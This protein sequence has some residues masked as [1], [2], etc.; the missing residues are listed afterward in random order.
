MHTL[1]P[2]F[3]ASL[4]LLGLSVVSLPVMAVTRTWPGAAPCNTTL[5]ACIAGTL[6]GDRIEIATDTPINESPNLFERDIELVAANG[7][8]PQLS[9]GRNLFI[10]SSQFKGNQTVLV[11]GIHLR[12]GY[13]SANYLGYATANYTIQ[14]MTLEA[15]PGNLGGRISSSIIR[16][17]T[18]ARTTLNLTLYNND[19][20]CGAAIAESSVVSMTSAASTTL[21]AN[22]YNNKVTCSTQDGVVNY[23]IL[24]SIGSNAAGVADATLK[25]HGNEIRAERYTGSGTMISSMSGIGIREDSDAL[26]ASTISARLYNN[27]VIG[28]GLNSSSNGIFTIVDRGDMNLQTV[29]NTI[30]GW[31]SSLYAGSYNSPGTGSQTIHGLILNNV[32]V[33]R[34]PAFYLQGTTTASLSNTYN[35]V[36]APST[37]TPLGG[38]SI[39]SPAKLVSEST[40]RLRSDSPAIGAADTATLAFG[41]ALGGLPG[42]D[43]DGLRRVKGADGLADIGAYEF[44]DVS[45]EHRVNSL[46]AGTHNSPIYSAALDG[47]TSALPQASQVHSTG[48]SSAYEPSFGVYYSP[49]RWRLFDQAQVDLV[50]GTTFNVFAPA[51][52]GGLLRH[53][54]TPAS[55][56]SYFT[57]ID[58]SSLNNKPDLILLATQNWD[59]N[60]VYNPHPI[61]L[62][63][64]G[65]NWYVDN[66]DYAAMPTNAAFNLYWQNPSPNAFRVT[67]SP[68]NLSVTGLRVDHPLLD[69]QPCA[70]PHATR[71]SG[72]AFV[73]H[74]W[75]WFYG[76]GS[77]NLFSPDGIPDGTQFNVVVDP[78]QV[79]L[80]TDRIFANDF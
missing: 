64:S 67:A 29:N 44:G 65:M 77:W 38:N 3:P 16:N 42:T 5:Q 15:S 48:S 31:Y 62:G 4:L 76:G 25:F 52:G 1:N 37:G 33:S 61:S 70:R 69:G 22:V 79:A 34:G 2:R 11:S 39:M 14:N 45:F 8:R 6:S 72:S 75:K 71:M 80:C 17:S 26:A 50:L 21:N 58:N 32:M 40:P 68:S 51:S 66:I 7:Y 18:A 73:A 49:N 74:G 56:A 27:V 12:N 46:I 20:H 53:I 47:V 54:A 24:A 10:S 59:P 23:G 19:V 55:I 30:T 60:S 57:K 36:N 41:I 43:A 63:F 28:N 35:L 13:V 78:A 9:D